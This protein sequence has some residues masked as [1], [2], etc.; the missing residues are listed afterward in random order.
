MYLPQKIHPHSGC[1]VRLSHHKNAR[2]WILRGRRSDIL[3]HGDGICE[4]TIG[5]HYRRWLDPIPGR[6]AM[7]RSPTAGVAHICPMNMNTRIKGTN[8]REKIIFYWK[9]RILPP[10]VEE[11]L[12]EELSGYSPILTNHYMTRA[13]E[14]LGTPGTKGDSHSPFPI[15]S[16]NM[17]SAARSPHQRGACGWHSCRFIVSVS[18]AFERGDNDQKTCSKFYETLCMCL[19]CFLF[20]VDLEF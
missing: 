15:L 6:L 9:W 19:E 4:G 17:I 20:P 3:P 16:I 7:W 11:H 10:V 14:E 5:W 12:A 1:S 8:N 13:S 2:K 18:R